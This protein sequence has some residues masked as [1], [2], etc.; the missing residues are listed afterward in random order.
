MRVQR[1]EVNASLGQ[2]FLNHTQLQALADAEEGTPSLVLMVLWEV[3]HGRAFPTSSSDMRFK[4]ASFTRRLHEAVRKDTRLSWVTSKAVKRPLLVGLKATSQVLWSVGLRQ[5]MGEGFDNAWRELGRLMLAEGV[6]PGG[7]RGA[8]TQMRLPEANPPATSTEARSTEGPASG[9]TAVGGRRQQRGKAE[10]GRGRARGGAKGRGRAM[11]PQVAET[12]EDVDPPAKRQKTG[13]N[14]RSGKKREKRK[15]EEQEG[16][17]DDNEDD[18]DGD[19]ADG[20]RRKQTRTSHGARHGRA[21]EGPP[22]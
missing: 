10:R 18:D 20:S 12:G 1:L 2:W 5:P 6:R 22:S 17:Y 15:R 16:N 3:D 8:A 21:Q 9:S 11:A 14:T 19:N 4:V 7:K 13:R